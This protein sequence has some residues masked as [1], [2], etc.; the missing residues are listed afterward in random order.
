MSDHHIDCL[1][2]D[3]SIL[4]HD[5]TEIETGHAIEHKWEFLVDEVFD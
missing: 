1:I 2:L 4:I 3:F 5:A